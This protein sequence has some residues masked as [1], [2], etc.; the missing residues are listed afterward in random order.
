MLKGKLYGHPEGRWE[1]WE[2]ASF[3]AYCVCYTYTRAVVLN[4]G[5]KRVT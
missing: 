4:P 3:P 2:G 1:R 5:L